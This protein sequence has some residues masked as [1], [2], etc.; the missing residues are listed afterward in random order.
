MDTIHQDHLL[1][2]TILYTST[3]VT[4]PGAFHRKDETKLMHLIQELACPMYK[5]MGQNST[6]LK[7]VSGGRCKEHNC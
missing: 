7:T 3:D 5:G 2:I 4:Q 1:T 6:A